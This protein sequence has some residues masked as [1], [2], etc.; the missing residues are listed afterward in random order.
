MLSKYNLIKKIIFEILF[1]RYK[2]NP[3]GKNIHI[4]LKDNMFICD[5]I[6]DHNVKII[7]NENYNLNK[8]IGLIENLIFIKFI[9]LKILPIHASGLCI[10]KKGFLFA[11]YGGTGKTRLILE[12]YKRKKNK[13]L[14][15]DE[16]CLAKEKNVFPLSDQI[17]LMYY[18]ISSNLNLFK[19]LD[20][21]RAFLYK[22]IPTQ[23]L[24]NLLSYFKIVLKYKFINFS[25]VGRF[26]VNKV[27]FLKNSNI[28]DIKI[29]RVTNEKM[30]NYI[31]K[32]FFH[33]KK[34]IEI[35]KQ[36]NSND[37]LNNNRNFINLYK[38][39][40]KK[41][42]INKDCLKLIFQ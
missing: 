30:I 2:F 27:L 12:S 15:F 16:W 20:Y 4:A 32:N 42:L 10:N 41:F 13:S 18:D 38:S 39:L 33:E 26:P 40:V 31:T 19:K 1:D 5:S 35:V 8:L 17:L 9:Q 29:K 37:R 28:K 11:S 24:K 23:I 3:K 6:F 14:I 36:N 25:N 7:V 21:Y 22:I 34:L